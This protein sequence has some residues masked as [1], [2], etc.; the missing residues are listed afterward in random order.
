MRPAEPWGTRHY[1]MRLATP[2][3]NLAAWQKL[4]PLTGANDF[5]AVRDGA[6][7]LAE[8]QNGQPLLVAAQPGGRVLAFAA[9]STWRWAMHGSSD[10]H[11]RFWR[12]AI[13][14]LARKD[15]V[16]QGDVWV[17]MDSRRYMPGQ[18]VAFE[19][20]A[21]SPE[22]DALPEAS[23]TATLRHP[24]NSQR[25]LR[26]VRHGDHF[27]GATSDCNEPGTY[28]ITVVARADD[29]D[30]GQHESRF[31]VYTK[32]RELSG[33]T[34]DPT[35]LENLA[36]QTRE[37]GGRR[38]TPEELPALLAELSEKPLQLEEK[39]KLTVKYWDRGYLFVLLI[40]VLSTE[41]FLRKKWRL[42]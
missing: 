3:D 4:P 15:E 1:L 17:R 20:G 35:L 11:R 21:R 23:L 16:T 22:G 24:D 27:R 42:V 28:T 38:L 13:L 12:Q 14:W 26:L 40:A 36:A 39:V 5:R 6:E 10:V 18:R 7:V 32:D 37:Q 29:K 25:P 41:W 34:A 19:A 33:V 9:D 2:N 30:I 31:M 8:D